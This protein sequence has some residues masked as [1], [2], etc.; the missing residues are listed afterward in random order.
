VTASPLRA[1]GAEDDAAVDQAIL[2][3]LEHLRRESYRFVT[4][5]RSTH[6]RVRERRAASRED[7]LRD[8]FGWVR[9]AAPGMLP[10]DL[11]QSLLEAGLLTLS[12]GSL[13][14]RIRVSSIDDLLLVHSAPEAGR[15]SVFLGP[16]SYRYARFL[17]QTLSRLPP[18][19]RAIDIGVGAGVGALTLLAHGLAADVSGTDVNPLALRYAQLNAVH[20]GLALRPRLADGLPS[21]SDRYDLIIANPPFIAGRTGAIYK[22]GGDDYGSGVALQWTKVGIDRLND[23][24]HLTLYT[25]APIVRGVDLVKQAL[26][27]QVR[28]AGFSL[29]YEEIDPDIFGGLLGTEAYRTVERIAAVGAVVSA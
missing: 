4:P 6:Q 24:G 23:G 11:E 17:R 8:V 21:S 28:R 18:A 3:L 16:D 26:S 9:P 19:R 10:R 7:L 20:A 12:Q 29:A 13:K 2:G 1:S 15:D 5:H 25:G 22:D 27:D 14:S